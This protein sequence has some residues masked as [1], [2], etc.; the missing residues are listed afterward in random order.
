MG[1]ILSLAPCPGG[2]PEASWPSAKLTGGLS[3]PSGSPRWPSWAAAGRL[4]RGPPRVRFSWGWGCLCSQIWMDSAMLKPSKE[5]EDHLGALW[6]GDQRSALLSCTHLALAGWV[7][8]SLQETLSGLRI[9]LGRQTTLA[10]RTPGAGRISLSSPVRRS[11]DMREA[12]S[13]PGKGAPR[14]QPATQR[15]EQGKPT[16][17]HLYLKGTAKPTLHTAFCLLSA[18]I[19]RLN[20]TKADSLRGYIQ[21]QVWVLLVFFFKHFSVFF[22]FFF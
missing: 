17:S 19:K 15:Q 2:Q 10:R 8:W 12:P 22:F 18:A 20:T 6:P 16:F 11:S 7:T 5:S 13:S 3:F 4:P 21:T 9:K 14:R 1:L